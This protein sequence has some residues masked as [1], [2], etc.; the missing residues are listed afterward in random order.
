MKEGVERVKELN[1][2]HEQFSGGFETFRKEWLGRMESMSPEVRMYKNIDT[3]LLGWPT[4]SD[5]E[6]QNR[7]EA[8]FRSLREKLEDH[9]DLKIYL[10]LRASEL[11]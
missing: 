1:Q 10:A 4:T 7:N 2:E 5:S 11:L 6:L 9:P 3:I 8:K